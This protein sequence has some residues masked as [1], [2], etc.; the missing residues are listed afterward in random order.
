VPGDG[1]REAHGKAFHAPLETAVKFLAMTAND[2]Q[3]DR[4]LC[5]AAGMDNYLSK[6]VKSADLQSALLR[7]LA[8]MSEDKVISST[9]VSVN[10]ANSPPR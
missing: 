4:A 7:L 3:G 5:L 2:M 6:P 8:G 10:F 1:Q 9:P